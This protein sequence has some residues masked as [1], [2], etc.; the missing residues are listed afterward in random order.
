VYIIYCVWM[1]RSHAVQRKLQ[2]ILFLC[3]DTLACRQFEGVFISEKPENEEFA[4]AGAILDARDIW[5]L[6][7]DRFLRASKM[8]PAIATSAFTGV[9]RD[10]NT[11]KP[12]ASRLGIDPKQRYCICITGCRTSRK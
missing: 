3:E 11:L 1:G 2:P 4:I 10:K 9:F 8:A 12:P 6:A 7:P 5:S